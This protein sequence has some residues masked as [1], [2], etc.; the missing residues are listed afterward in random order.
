MTQIYDYIIVG[1]GSAGCALANRLSREA[2][3]RVLLLEAGGKDSNPMVHIPLGFAFTMK[4]PKTSWCYKTEPEPHLN[5][6]ELDWPRG[7]VLGG[8]SSINGMVYIR[9]QKEDYDAWAEAGN[10]GWGYDDLLPYF[11]RSEHNVRGASRY[12]GIGGGLWV[13]EPTDKMEL[14]QLYIQAGIESGIPYNED[15]NG[16]RQEGI[17]YYQL[18][19]KDGLRQ[20]SAKTFLKQC[21][22]RPNL[23]LQTHALTTRIEFDGKKATAIKYRQKGKEMRAECRGEIILCGG[24]INSPQ[25]L[26]LSGIGD[27]EFLQKMGI[28]TVHH[29]P[30]VGENLQ[31]HLTVNTQCSLTDVTTFHDELKPLGMVKNLAKLAFKRKGLLIHPASQVGAFFRTTDEV[32]RPDAQIHFTPAAGE[33]DEKG[34]INPLP[35]TTA[36]VCYLR[37]T[38]RGSVHLR[39]RNPETHPLIRANYLSTEHDVKHT[40]AAV[41]KTRDIFKAPSLKKY[42]RGELMPGPDVDNDEKLLEYIRNISESVYHPV[43]TCKMG[44]DELAVV[45]D[46]LRVHGVENLRIADGSIMPTI[47]SGNT[48]ATCVL[49]GERCA[50]FIL[51]KE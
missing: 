38:S 48:N 18:N 50:D 28:K 32:E 36:T 3:R 12:H 29:L 10:R 8:S 16:E 4:D 9:G 49:I 42:H 14:A 34:R 20:S 45:D 17:G 19:I 21:I 11:R 26:E 23:D 40:L 24:T 37:P 39:A 7:K 33:P 30:G 1:A 35:G 13:D 6:R 43:G 44:H 41:Q 25:L 47:L 46:R 2:S 15:F 5:D 51:N 27:G 22:D 31:D